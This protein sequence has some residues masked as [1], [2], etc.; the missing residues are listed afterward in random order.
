M[1]KTI[2]NKKLLLTITLLISAQSIFGAAAAEYKS[3]K[4]LGQESSPIEDYF[5]ENHKVLLCTAIF[6][7]SHSLTVKYKELSEK[8]ENMMQ[9]PSTFNQEERYKERN[10]TLIPIEENAYEEQKFNTYRD[11]LSHSLFSSLSRM[12][13]EDDRRSTSKIKTKMVIRVL[14]EFTI[15]HAEK[16]SF[17]DEL[18][19]EN[20]KHYLAIHNLYYNICSNF[21][22]FLEGCMREDLTLNKIH[23]IKYI[24]EPIKE[25]LLELSFENFV[26]LDLPV[27]DDEQPEGSLSQDDIS[28]EDTDL[29][30]SSD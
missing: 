4:G 12:L 27:I 26:T 21:L 10:I 3:P 5:S 15:H 7:E 20:K 13:H 8:F 28:S 11:K 19:Q 18:K 23:L 30:E 2:M 25:C 1:E 17:Y 6:L 9:D 24:F 14:E 22:T 29:S 16:F